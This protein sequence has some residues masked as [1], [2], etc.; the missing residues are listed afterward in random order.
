[1]TAIEPI[2][3]GVADAAALTPETRDEV[4]LEVEQGVVE[5]YRA[6]SERIKSHARAFSPDLQPAGF[7]ILRYINAREP[8]RAAD[9][10]TSLGMDKSAVSRQVTVLREL[11]L[12][13]TMP[14][15]L[16]GRAS[17]LVL[18]SASRNALSG[19]RSQR[20]TDYERVLS[21]WSDADLL[22]FAELLKRFTASL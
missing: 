14:D 10:A 21:Q 12:V 13:E 11:G 2:G 4:A 5:L 19:I 18:S 9:I 7:G 15:P 17:L 22:S 16:D 3:G 20:S 1:M 6:V 8:I